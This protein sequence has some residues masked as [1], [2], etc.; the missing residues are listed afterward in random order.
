VNIGHVKDIS[1][2]MK[3]GYKLEHRC[4]GFFYSCGAAH[5][6]RLANLRLKTTTA[7]GSVWARRK[8]TPSQTQIELCRNRCCQLAEAVRGFLSIQSAALFTRRR[9]GG[10]SIVTMSP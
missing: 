5:S 7:V 6:G 9:V 10:P 2:L 4:R 1:S 8:Y 3:L